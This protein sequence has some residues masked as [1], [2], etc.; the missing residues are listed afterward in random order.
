[1]LGRLFKYEMKAT[2]K[3]LLPIYAA[4]IAIA[5]ITRI[6]LEFQLDENSPLYFL[7]DISTLVFA[8]STMAMFVITSVVIVWR[9]YRNTSSDEGYLLFTLPVKTDYI[10]L[11]EFLCGFFWCVVMLAATII[12]MLLLLINRN[13]DGV[14]I[15][16]T[17]LGNVFS[18]FSA[19]GIK[20][21]FV[22]L[23]NVI[24]SCLAEIMMA[25]CAIAIAS[26]FRKYRLL[27]SATF[28]IALI[29]VIN[30][31]DVIVLRMITNY[32]IDT[33]NMN[34]VYDINSF[35]N[36]WNNVIAPNMLSL[37][38]LIDFIYVAVIMVVEYFVIRFILK[39][40]LNLY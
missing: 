39:K 5:G 7:I 15:N 26:L 6:T 19:D 34:D 25:Y 14:T 22:F 21:I 8:L 11:S 33:K 10:I 29:V 38:V 37:E 40:H 35:V 28:Y 20:M 30:L 32:S 12:G 17:F 2:A 23:A 4:F 24:L 3:I 16:F 18:L 9:F 13:I 1:M 27:L 36:V 31:I